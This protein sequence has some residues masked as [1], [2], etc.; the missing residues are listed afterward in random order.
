MATATSTTFV[1]TVLGIDL[2]T[3]SCRVTELSLNKRMPAVVRNNLSNESSPSILYYPANDATCTSA[4]R[5]FGEPV[6]AKPV[7]DLAHCVVDIKDWILTHSSEMGS[8]EREFSEA[9]AGEDLSLGAAQ[10]LTYALSS[11]MKF[12]S[13]NSS[14]AV[15]AA[16]AI[17]LP[18]SVSN[19]DAADA[20]SMAARRKVVAEAFA[21][22]LSKEKRA[23]TGCSDDV[24]GMVV[25]E[26]EAIAAYVHHLLYD[27]IP[28]AADGA[29]DGSATKPEIIAVVNVGHA[30]CTVVLVQ[31]SKGSCKVLASASLS[32]VGSGLIDDALTKIVFD[33]ILQK[34]KVDI[35]NH[36]KSYQK[37]IRECQKAKTVLS[38]V[39]STL[40]QLEGLAQDVDVS[41]R[42]TRDMVNEAAKEALVA[43]LIA[44]IS[45]K[46]LPSLPEGTESVRVEAVGGGWRSPCV[47]EAV[48]A[49]FPGAQRLGVSLD[50]NLCVAEGTAIVAAKLL[51]DTKKQ[52]ETLAE[53]EVVE[54]GAVVEKPVA[55]EALGAFHDA[56][57]LSIANSCI[58]WVG[59]ENAEMPA[60]STKETSLEAAD[61]A[62]HAKMRVIDA[63]ESFCFRVTNLIGRC[64]GENALTS[65]QQDA[66]HAILAPLNDLIVDASEHSSEE[67]DA[68][69]SAARAK[70]FGE[71]GTEE[72]LAPF[73]GLL[74]QERREVE[75][76][77]AKDKELEELSKQQ[78]A[79]KELKS[80]PQRLRMAQQRREQGAK[81]F[82]EEMW[83]EAQT[84]FVQAL[85]AIGQLYDITSPENKEK[86]DEISLSCHLNIASCAVKLGKW[87]IALNNA[88][89]ALDVK[90][91]H[92]KALFR[93]GQANSAL[94]EYKAAAAD[95][96]KA[97]ELTNS[98]A[99]VMAELALLQ[100]KIEKEKAREKKMFSKMFA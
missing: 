8:G 97:K 66:I 4:A 37:V 74:A 82:K 60:W 71:A 16:V 43:P 48:L 32:G 85:S 95:L 88:N 44:L 87:R 64:R 19:G 98:D 23:S 47:Q 68:A 36:Q 65:A 53:E 76:Q 62:F 52:K 84:R 10:V 75:E 39:D 15:R 70:I 79:D 1:P 93:R 61:A 2:G 6:S 11:L 5:G 81:L 9:S 73:P 63:A 29:D 91:D 51:L 20:A 55:T 90:P 92:P 33:H 18:V 77:E 7:G 56:L 42:L 100:Q 78:E 83:E 28:A 24:V 34:N 50:A 35:R 25:D 69:I 17:C 49:A 13:T 45:A 67:F 21:Y 96:N 80:D 86:K 40:V 59:D 14:S 27:S 58:V 57:S 41:I 30:F 3:Q 54:E 38:S 89:S 99:G 46:I 22:A 26:A 31:V 72:A 12:G 94:G